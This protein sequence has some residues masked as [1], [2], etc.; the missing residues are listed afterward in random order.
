MEVR[1]ENKPVMIEL[2]KPGYA[3][4]NWNDV[5]PNAK[6]VRFVLHPSSRAEAHLDKHKEPPGPKLVIGK[7]APALDVETWVHLPTGKP[8]ELP[9]KDGRRTFVLFEWNCDEPDALRK[10]VKQLD[11]EA[12][13]A[14]AQAIVLFGPHSHERGVRAMLGNDTPANVSIAI[15]RFIPDCEYDVSGAT[16]LSYGFGRMPHAF[17]V[18]EKGTV[19]HDQ[20]GV[21]KLAD[22]AR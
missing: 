9:A 14:N 5:P 7:P 13:K 22:V 4:R 1:G 12:K 21:A 2:R 18:D 16:M 6:D 17:V 10:R 20:S 15:D 19:R 11:A 8:P 3:M